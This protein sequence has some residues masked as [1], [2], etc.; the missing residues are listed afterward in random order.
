MLTHYLTRYLKLTFSTFFIIFIFISMQNSFACSRIVK[1]DNYGA[2][3]AGRTM[4]WLNNMKTNLWVYPQGISHD[5]LSIVNPLKWTSKYGSIIANIYDLFPTDGMNEKGFA[6]HL[7]WLSASDYGRRDEKL[8][9]LSVLQWA[10]F[11]LDNFATVVEALDYTEKNP[12]QIVPAIHPMT[13]RMVTVHL[14]IEDATGD[15]GVIEVLNGKTFIFHIPQCGVLTNDPP[16]TEQLTNLKQYI[17]FGGDKPLPGST[18]STDRF[19]RASYYLK[20]LPS[21]TDMKDTYAEIM[22]VMDSINEPYGSITLERPKIS[23]T[24]WRTLADLN[25]QIYYFN[26]SKEFNMFWAPLSEFNLKPDAPTMKLDLSQNHD[27]AG[28]VVNKF[29]PVT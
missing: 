28:D 20:Y 5:D 21:S 7:L 10:Q 11:Y 8:P 12:F 18:E 27:L 14:A 17:G 6:A 24:I 9:G 25:H 15:T 22:S 2:V 16:L 4:D 29:K 3:F 26:F 23:F 19:V 13:D 1:K